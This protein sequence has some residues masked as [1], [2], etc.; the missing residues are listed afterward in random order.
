MRVLI[1]GDYYE[2]LKD[3][4]GAR[5]ATAALGAALARGGNELIVCTDNPDTADSE[6]AGGALGSS[7]TDFSLTVYSPAGVAYPFSA[8]TEGSVRSVR[9]EVSPFESWEIVHMEAIQYADIILLV[10]GAGEWRYVTKMLGMASVAL[11]KIVVPV[12]S[13]GGETLHVWDSIATSPMRESYRTMGLDI[14]YLNA[15]WREGESES[16]I[17]EMIQHAFRNRAMIAGATWFT[18]GRQLSRSLAAAF[19]LFALTAGLWF[20]VLSTGLKAE[21]PLA[22][23]PL[24]ALVLLA[25]GIGAAANAVYSLWRGDVLSF[26]SQAMS[27]LVGASGGL[28]SF[29]LFLLGQ[30]VFSGEVLTALD[31]PTSFMRNALIASFFGLFSGLFIDKGYELIRR[32]GESIASSLGPKPK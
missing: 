13:F 10:G 8:V 6:F 9:Y 11:R 27:L 30:L 20:W 26:S 25:G 22:L 7:G 15:P 2:G 32:S 23:D 14:G 3:P 29:V 19:L 21:Y 16:I 18:T 1:I 12:A 17:G 4:E 5:S 31:D 24:F 28:V